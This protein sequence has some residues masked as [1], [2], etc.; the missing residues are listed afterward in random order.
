MPVPGPSSVASEREKLIKLIEM[1]PSHSTEELQDALNFHVTVEMAALALSSKVANDMSD[2]DTVLLQPTFLPKDHG[3]IT[4]HKVIEH[5]QRNFISDKEKVKVDEDD[6][7]NG[8]LAYYKDSKFDARKKL[9][10]LY[11]GQ[12]AADTGGVTRQFYTQ[13]LQEISQHNSSFMVTP[14]KLPFTTPT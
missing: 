6:I 8:A 12:P 1:F 3:V 7:F 11:K 13:L 5:I 4:L 10:I 9:R 14:L 2:F